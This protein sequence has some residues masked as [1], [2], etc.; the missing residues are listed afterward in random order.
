MAWKISLNEARCTGCRICEMICS[1]SDEGGFDPSRS[2]ITVE[3]IDE[4][5]AHFSIRFDPGCKNCGLCA[6][7]CASK[8]LVKEKEQRDG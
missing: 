6:T 1:W 5:D 8:A 3:S 7:Y 2:L 4:K